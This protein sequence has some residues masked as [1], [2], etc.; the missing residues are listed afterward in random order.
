DNEISYIP[1]SETTYGQPDG[2]FGINCGHLPQEVFVPGHTLLLGAEDADGAEDNAQRYAQSQRQRRLECRVRA[3]KREAIT[4]EA[5]GDK[6]G[7]DAAALRVR[8][9]QGDLRAFEKETGRTHY[10]DRSQVFGY[11]RSVAGKANTALAL[12]KKRVAWD[13]DFDDKH[14]AKTLDELL[15][16][17]KRA[18]NI[19]EKLSAYTLNQEHSRGKHKAIVFERALGYNKD[20]AQ[21][22]AAQIQNGLKKYRAVSTGN[23]GFG[24]SYRVTMLI[25]GAGSKSDVQQPVETGWIIRNGEKFPRMVNAIVGKGKRP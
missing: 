21:E 14:R 10:G 2:L 4:L 18:E 1:L 8:R 25:N 5:A 9:A 12:R 13:R 3:A 17:H 11:N 7:F 20:I 23:N 22:L 16:S 24:E 15:P 6:E 19:R